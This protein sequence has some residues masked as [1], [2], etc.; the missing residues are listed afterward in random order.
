MGVQSLERGLVLLA[1]VAEHRRGASLR[2]LC[3]DTGIAHSTAHR[4]LMTLAETGFVIYSAQHRLYHI[5]HALTDIAEKSSTNS[6]V[7]PQPVIEMSEQTG[8]TVFVCEWSAREAVCV[9]LARSRHPLQLFVR[10]GQVMP[11]YAAASARMLLAWQPPSERAAILSTLTTTRFTSGTVTSPEQ[12]T[13]HLGTIRERGYDICDSELDDG[14]WAVAYPVHDAAGRVRSS[15]TVAV[16]VQRVRSVAAQRHL[17]QL[18]S[19]CAARLSA[20]LGW[21]SSSPV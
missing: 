12:L 15:V 17:Q 18:V 11:V 10:I 6:A 4:A 5:G 13:T 19:Q 14:I 1:A 21:D 20:E 7:T 16:P 3:A 9:A 2:D 8:E